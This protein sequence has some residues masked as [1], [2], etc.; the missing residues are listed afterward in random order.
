MGWSSW[1]MKREPSTLTRARARCNQM[2]RTVVRCHFLSNGSQVVQ[3]AR[4]RRFDVWPTLR[5]AS[6][7][8]FSPCVRIPSGFLY[9]CPTADFNGAIE[10]RVIRTRWIHATSC[11]VHRPRFITLRP[12]PLS[13]PRL[14]IRFAHA[15]NT[16]NS[17]PKS[18]RGALCPLP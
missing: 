5:A 9:R 18:T 4:I 11:C 7:D 16:A 2:Y 8:D 14:R 17:R 13:S 15:W 10:H 3:R 6:R 1:R 12:S